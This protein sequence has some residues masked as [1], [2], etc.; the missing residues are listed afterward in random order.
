MKLDWWKKRRVE[1]RITIMERKKFDMKLTW[2]FN[3]LERENPIMEIEIT[4]NDGYFLDGYYFLDEATDLLVME[5]S[6]DNEDYISKICKD[7]LITS[8]VFKD[9]NCFRLV[10][11]G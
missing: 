9:K 3:F 4:A 8:P 5:L 11:E 2:F 6:D 10:Q 1:R 7:I